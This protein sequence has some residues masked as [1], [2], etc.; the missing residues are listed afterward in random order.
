MT[1]EYPSVLA[2]QNNELLALDKCKF[3]CLLTT[4]N[5]ISNCR[6]KRSQIPCAR[7]L[8]G[9]G[10]GERFERH[11]QVVNVSQMLATCGEFWQICQ[12]LPILKGSSL[13]VSKGQIRKVRFETNFF[14]QIVKTHILFFKI[15][16]T[17][18]LFTPIHTS[19]ITDK[20][21]KHTGILVQNLQALANM[22]NNLE[23]FAMLANHLQRSTR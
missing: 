4:R 3:R 22:S 14:N 1:H 18:T 23:M 16:N 20:M 10:P 13:A 21:G 15:H 12:S 11:T 17:S 6:V 19:P 9:H 2:S 5:T 8:A 7:G